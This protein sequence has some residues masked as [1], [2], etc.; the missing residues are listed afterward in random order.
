MFGTR[1]A[2]IC[3]AVILLPM[4]ILGQSRTTVGATGHLPSDPT[5]LEIAVRAIV[6]LSVVRT[7]GTE[8]FG[9]G[10]V[11]SAD[12]KIVTNFH[13]VKNAASVIA[14]LENGDKYDKVD[15]LDVDKRKDLVI[16]AIR[17]HNLSFA[18]LNYSDDIKIGESVF[19]VSNPL[20]ILTN[21]VSDGIISGIRQMDGYK[22]IQTTAPISQGSSGGA[23]LNPEGKLIGVLVS[24]LT[25]GQNLNFAIPINYVREM[26]GSTERRPIST[27][28]TREGSSAESEA[29]WTEPQHP[30]RIDSPPESRETETRGDV[31]EQVAKLSA[32]VV[33]IGL[34]AAMRSRM[35]IWNFEIATRMFGGA[36]NHRKIYD[37]LGLVTKDSYEWLDPTHKFTKFELQFDRKTAAM[38]SAIFY[39]RST[40]FESLEESAIRM[41]RTQDQ[42]NGS[43]LHSNI[44]ERLSVVEDSAGMITAIIIY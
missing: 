21:S 10:I 20:G 41:F 17:A 8:V 35:G 16:L 11:V 34:V 38:T 4:W 39:P 2:S 19:T 24:T 36:L 13:V 7:N 15:V 33:K 14:T 26:L 1:V 9:S 43:R 28:V 42:P 3:Y 32:E 37:P 5:P 25:L 44:N 12:G 29:E 27:L 30:A 23:L 31:S 40:P 6:Q 22:L 18:S